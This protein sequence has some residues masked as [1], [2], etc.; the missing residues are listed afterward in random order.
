[1]YIHKCNTYKTRC[2]QV[3]LGCNRTILM[4]VDVSIKKNA[5]KAVDHVHWAFDHVQRAFDHMQR[6]FAAAVFIK[7]IVFNVAGLSG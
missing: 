5:S 3:G 2:I 4:Q 1:M 7:H 6:A